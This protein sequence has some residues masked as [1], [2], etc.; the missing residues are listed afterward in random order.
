MANAVARGLD[1]REIDAE[2]ASTGA[3]GGRGED[4]CL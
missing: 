1:L 2:I 4:V 3:D